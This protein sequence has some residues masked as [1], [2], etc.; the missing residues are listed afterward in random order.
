MLKHS[1]TWG[2][3]LK[4]QGKLEDAINAYKKAISL[5]PDYARAHFNIGNTFM[6]QGELDDAVNSYKKA[7]SINPNFNEAFF[8]IGASLRGVSLTKADLSLQEIIINLLNRRCARPQD[9]AHAAISLLKFEPILQYQFNSLRKAGNDVL[10]GS[11][12][13]RL[14]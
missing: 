4:L 3:V 11:H 9:V 12:S 1:T 7:L 14:K 10:F 2:N 6:S 5:K 8:N 13:T